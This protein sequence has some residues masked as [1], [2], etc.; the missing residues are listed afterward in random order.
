M[1]DRSGNDGVNA[2]GAL[3]VAFKI[4]VIARSRSTLGSSLSRYTGWSRFLS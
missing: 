2:A 4:G 3:N 1:G